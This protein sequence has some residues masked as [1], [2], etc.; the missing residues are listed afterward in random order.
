MS[1]TKSFKTGTTL[2]AFDN[3]AP[4]R[5]KNVWVIGLDMGYSAVKVFTKNFVGA[6]P[7][8]AKKL[9]ANHVSLAKVNPTDIFYRDSSGDVWVVGDMAQKMINKNSTNDSMAIL[10]GRNRFFSDNFRVTSRVGLALGLQ[11]NMFGDPAGK[12]IYLQT[13]LPPRYLLD[14]KKELVDALTGHFE[15]EVKIGA[16]SWTKYEFQLEAED[17]HVTQQP[18]GTLVSVAVGKDGYPTSEAEKLYRSNTLIFDPGFR[19]GDCCL[20]EEG[21]IDLSQ[22]QTF[23]DISMIEVLTTF[24]NKVAKEYGVNI[25]IPAMQNV[26]EA[27]TI[28]VSDRRTMQS[29]FV[30]VSELLLE[31]NEEIC[32]KALQ[33]LSEAYEYLENID[34]LVITGG[35]GAAWAESLKKRLSG[36]ETIHILAGNE[37]DT[38]LSYVNANSRGYYM[39][40]VAQN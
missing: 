9:P 27:G 5:N 28:R 26:L 32:E 7:S 4:K 21:I 13:G 2:M 37:T 12:K 10:Y 30:D 16:G 39:Y 17:I 33:R 14:D 31:A 35:T 19:T 8:Y 20:I 24:G 40:A 6:F 36:N 11:K 23:D 34:Y 38:R 1:T 22:C 3:P 25:P 29:H 18:M 15:F